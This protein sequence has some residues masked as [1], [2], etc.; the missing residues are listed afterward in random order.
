MP[1]RAWRSWT[2]DLPRRTA[3]SWT[4]R[5][6]WVP[7]TQDSLRPPWTTRSLVQADA[8]GARLARATQRPGDSHVLMP[9]ILLPEIHPQEISLNML[10]TW[11][12]S[13]SVVR[14]QPANAGGRRCGFA[15]WVGKVH[16][17]RAWQ[18]TPGFVPGESHGQR[19]LVG[20]SLWGCKES[21]T[22]AHMRAATKTHLRLFHNDKNTENNLNDLTQET[23]RIW[24]V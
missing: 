10:K 24:C 1:S 19:S 3:P 2:P 8:D 14:H 17:R 5:A 4:P 6:L 21:D 22:T 16:W 12:P 20:Y 23:K 9:E 7:E 18:P 11:L 15:P 13:G